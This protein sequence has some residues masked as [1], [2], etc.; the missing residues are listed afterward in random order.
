VTR[1]FA[2]IAGQVSTWL[3]GDGRYGV[4]R[5]VRTCSNGDEAGTQRVRFNFLIDTSSV[6]RDEREG[7]ARGGLHASRPDLASNVRVQQR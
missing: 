1:H 5:R 7:T 3:Q 2:H 6:G 4:V